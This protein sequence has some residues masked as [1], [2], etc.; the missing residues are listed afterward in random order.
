M[1]NEWAQNWWDK[2]EIF[3]TTIKHQTQTQKKNP[4]IAGEKIKS[5]RGKQNRACIDR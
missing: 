2:R 5:I 4:A 1:N 3:N